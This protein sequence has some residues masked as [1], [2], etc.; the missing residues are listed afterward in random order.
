[1][2]LSALKNVGIGVALGCLLGLCVSVVLPAAGDTPAAPVADKIP[3]VI[4]AHSFLLVDHKNRVRA[5]MD[6]DPSDDAPIITM[7]DE[8]EKEFVQIGATE[9]GVPY[10]MLEDRGGT[11]GTNGIITPHPPAIIAI[12]TKNGPV[13]WRFPE[14]TE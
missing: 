1:M 8:G 2:N 12:R 9:E 4:Q 14:R 13:Q 5:S 7:Y 11:L 6:L 10:I 3:A